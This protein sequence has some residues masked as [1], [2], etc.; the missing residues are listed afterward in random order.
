MKK[1]SV[2]KN[3]EV[4]SLIDIPKKG[5][6]IDIGFQKL[7][8]QEDQVEGEYGQASGAAANN[9]SGG[10]GEVANTK[11]EKDGDDSEE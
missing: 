11:R 6:E 8:T 4:V 9:P 5:N 3:D 2:K 1:T 10:Q 7:N